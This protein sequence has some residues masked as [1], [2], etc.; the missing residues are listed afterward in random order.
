MSS[1]IT[2]YSKEGAKEYAQYLQAEGYHYSIHHT[3]KRWIVKLESKIKPGVKLIYTTEPKTSLAFYDAVTNTIK[4]NP[5]KESEFWKGRTPQLLAHEIGHARFKHGR[6]DTR[7]NAERYLRDEAEAV[8]YAYT[9]NHDKDELRRMINE[10]HQ[11]GEQEDMTPE[12]VNQII[13]DAQ[14]VVQEQL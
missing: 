3:G 14:S 8:I 5:D 6:S 11:I 1:G 10:L 7:W 9:K 12:E 4:F 2:F 13:K